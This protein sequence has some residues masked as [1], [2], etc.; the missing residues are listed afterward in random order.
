MNTLAGTP[1][2]LSPQNL[3][4]AF[5]GSFTDEENFVGSPDTEMYARE[6]VLRG[7]AMWNWPGSVADAEAYLA[8]L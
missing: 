8:G 6:I 1:A 2:W 5:W 3:A 4:Y 7:D